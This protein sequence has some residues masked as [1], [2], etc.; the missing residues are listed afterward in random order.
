MDAN[1]ISTAIVSVSTPGPW[2]GDVAAGRR[3]SRMWNDY[4]AEAIRNY[5]GRYGL[6]AVIPLPDTEGSLAGNRL[7]ARHAQGRRYRSVE[8]L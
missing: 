6:F 4:A 7:C 5:P 3:L 1:G 8:L 2:F